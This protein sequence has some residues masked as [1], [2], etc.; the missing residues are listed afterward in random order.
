MAL[1]YFG[2][3]DDLLN[4]M[5][6]VSIFMNMGFYIFFSSLVFFVWAFSVFV[7]DRLSDWRVT[8]GQLTHDAVIGV[9]R[10]VMT[11]AA[12]SSRSTARIC[13]G[14]G[15]S[16]SAPATS[17]YPRPGHVKMFQIPNVL[18]V[19]SKVGEIQHMIA[20]QPDQFQSPLT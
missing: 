6:R 11:H 16:A 7:Y 18:F 9:L 14:T 1:A 3:W 8:P 17:K 12:W 15:S 20:M 5:G 4:A 13:S 2:M 10:R 19:D